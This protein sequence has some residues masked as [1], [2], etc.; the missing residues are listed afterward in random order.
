MTP[1]TSTAPAIVCAAD[2][3]YAKYLA[4]TTVSLLEN[5][6]IPEEI[7]LFILDGGISESSREMLVRSWEPYRL[8]VVWIVPDLPDLNVFPT[9]GHISAVSY[10]RIFLGELLPKGIERVIYLDA[11]LVVESDILELWSLPL[12]E[13][14]CLASQ[15]LCAPFIDSERAAKNFSQYW[16]ILNSI[17]PIP[18]YESLGLDPLSEYFNAG[19]IYFDLAKWRS[20]GLQAK[21]IECLQENSEY[22]LWWDQYLLNVVLYGRWGKL[23]PRWNQTTGT[24]Q[25]SNWQCSPLEEEA[26]KEAV[27]RPYIRHYASHVKPWHFSY[28]GPGRKEF[29]KYLDR[30]AW[31]GWRPRFSFKELKRSVSFEIRN[32]IK[33]LRHQFSNG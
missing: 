32:R 28:L 19:V 12:G 11:D 17:R 15:D 22:L 30:T 10:F 4:V 6:S 26:F 31:A 14:V 3:N 18:N 5:C 2:E 29:F 27:S 20:E 8:E 24:F 1:S 7:R 33:Q 23:S 13:S 16:R 25:F 21:A 9:S